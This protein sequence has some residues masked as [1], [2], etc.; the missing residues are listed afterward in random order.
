[1]K[2]FVKISTKIQKTL[3]QKISISIVWWKW[4]KF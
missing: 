4:L 1:M 2:P 3:F